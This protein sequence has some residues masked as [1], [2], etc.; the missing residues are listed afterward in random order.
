MESAPGNCWHAK[1][2]SVYLIRNTVRKTG[3]GN[4]SLF[5]IEAVNMKYNIKISELVKK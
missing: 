5:S 4:T 2:N 3:E 1:V